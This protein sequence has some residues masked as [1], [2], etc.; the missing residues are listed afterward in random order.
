M[1]DSFFCGYFVFGISLEAVDSATPVS[2]DAEIA[3]S[4]AYASS[5]Q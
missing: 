5:S 1:V 4:S 2:A 3:A